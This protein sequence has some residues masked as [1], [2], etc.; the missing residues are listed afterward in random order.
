LDRGAEVAHGG[1]VDKLVGGER[2]ARNRSVSE[3][4]LAGDQYH[5]DRLPTDL[6]DFFDP[7]E[8]ISSIPG[9]SGGAYLLS[10]IV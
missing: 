10:N 6:T 9:A 8:L 2:P 4:G 5:W 7:L 1:G 3:V